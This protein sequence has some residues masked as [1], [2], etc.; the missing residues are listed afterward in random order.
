MK[1]K[2]VNEYIDQAP[3]QAREKLIELRH[4]L[5]GIPP[6]AV[7]KFRLETPIMEEK[8]I[9]FAFAAFRS[10]MNFLPAA[11]SLEPGEEELKALKPVKE[12]YNRRMRNHY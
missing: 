8:R 12:Q 7:E 9:L 4:L 10:R 3:G 2:T 6:D 1:P 11:A 5:K